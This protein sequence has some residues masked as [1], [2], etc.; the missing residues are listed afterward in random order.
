MHERHFHFHFVV[1]ARLYVNTN[2]SSHHCMVDLSAALCNV[3]SIQ[4]TKHNSSLSKPHQVRAARFYK[5][6]CSAMQPACVRHFWSNYFVI[7]MDMI[8]AKLGRASANQ[9]YINLPYVH[10][11]VVA[12]ITHIDLTSWQIQF[13]K[14]FCRK[15]AQTTFFS[16]TM[17]FSLM[18]FH[19]KNKSH[20]KTYNPHI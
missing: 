9:P 10:S 14:I 2:L 1:A 13:L 17:I 6:R 19:G 7:T 15:I 5:S 4:L 20:Y 16:L 11:S 18:Y 12:V 8:K 3:P